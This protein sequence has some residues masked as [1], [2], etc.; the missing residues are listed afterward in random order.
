MISLGDRHWAIIHPQF[1]DF[2]DGQRF[3]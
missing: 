3:S 2:N 1:K